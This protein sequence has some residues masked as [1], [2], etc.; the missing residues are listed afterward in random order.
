VITSMEKEK[1]ADSFSLAVD[2]RCV[3]GA[4]I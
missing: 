2:E 3:K 1:F 4:G